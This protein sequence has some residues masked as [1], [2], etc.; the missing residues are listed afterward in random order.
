[1]EAQGDLGVNVLGY[2]IGVSGSTGLQTLAQGQTGPLGTIDI[3]IFTNTSSYTAAPTSQTFTVYYQNLPVLTESASGLTNQTSDTISVSASV[4][5]VPGD[6]ITG[7]EIYDV[8]KGAIG[9]GAT[10]L[11]AATLSSG[12]WTYTASQLADGSVHD[13]EAVATDSLKNSAESEPVAAVD[14]VTEAPTVSASES[15]SGPTTETSDTF[16]V[17]AIAA[18]ELG[19]AIAGVEI[20]DSGTAIG[21]ATLANGVWTYTASNLD[22]GAHDFSAV[23]TDLAGN[24]TSAALTEVDVSTQAPLVYAWQSAFG[25]T[26]QN[27]DTITVSTDAESVPGDAIKG[28]EIYDGATAIGAA[29]Y[30]SV[31]GDWTYTASNLA[32]GVH[33]FSA[34][35]NDLA[36]NSGSYALEQIDVL[37]AQLET[38]ASNFSDNALIAD[39]SGDLFGTN[40]DSVFE[41]PKTVSGY[42]PDEVLAV[43]NGANDLALFPNGLIA[44]ANGDLLGTTAYGGSNDDGMVFG[45]PKTASGYGPVVTLDNFGVDDDGVS[46]FAG[47]IADANGDL[48]GT[49]SGITTSSVVVNDGTV[50]EIPKSAFGYGPV[51]TL[52]RFGVGNDG[53]A[54]FAGLIIDAD[55]DLFGTTAGGGPNSDGIVFEIAKTA[56]GYG[57]VTDLADFNGANGA[58]P[59][60]GLV[61]DANG[62]LFGTTAAGGSDDDGTVFEI[63]KTASSFGPLTTLDSFDDALSDLNNGADPLAGLIVDAKGDLF[64]TTF[65]GGSYDQG[66]VFEIPKTASGYGPI[67]IVADFNGDNGTEPEAS[68][69]ANAAGDLFG[70]TSGYDFVNGSTEFEITDTGF[71]PVTITGDTGGSDATSAIVTVNG[72]DYL[73]A[74][75]D[76]STQTLTGTGLV[77]DTV[78]LYNGSTLVASGITVNSSGN[79][80]YQIGQLVDG[81]YSYTATLSFAG[82]TSP[83]SAAVALTVATK[84]P[85]VSASESV[86][87]PTNQTSDTITVSA[88]AEAVGGDAIAGVE[89]YNGATA[90]GAATQANG[91]WTYTSSNLA[92]GAYDF[93]VVATDLA[94]NSATAALAAVDVATQVPTVTASESGLGADRPDFRHNHGDGERRNRAGQC[95]YRCRDLRRRHGPGGGDLCEWGVDLYSVESGRRRA[96]LFRRRHGPRG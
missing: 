65:A 92:D 81:S 12:V 75:N 79:W 49:T 10:D 82:V 96:R 7:V 26:D 20:Y 41:I 76:V 60:A 17:T 16:T 23:A 94:G 61:A 19:D 93:S 54:P 69:I 18:A 70:T 36:G 42:G 38:I 6:A 3:P 68:L 91:E 63:P 9:H 44:D 89:I 13:F 8:A 21:A 71:V 52:D 53:D 30:S 73:D 86:S 85:T 78:S 59:R 90:L 34:V 48:F 28:V 55:D 39:A 31:T 33:D 56:S 83:A 88:S 58:D 72:V 27:S 15:V 64:G 25:F 57:P 47:L 32:A 46:P 87:G 40:I 14:V 45:I 37:A 95:D 74:A 5:G 24:S 43:L 80:K 66:T 51:I 2:N 35:A 11:G 22:D 84:A 62:D 1:M 29:S 50:F 4:A 77:G 67:T